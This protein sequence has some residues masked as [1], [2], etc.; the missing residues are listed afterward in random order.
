MLVLGLMLC[1]ASSASAQKYICI[2]E[3]DIERVEVVK[4]PRAVQQYG[5]QPGEGIIVITTKVG[6]GL[7]P[8]FQCPKPSG[9]GD[10]QLSTK[11]Y[12]PDLVMENQKAIGLSDSQRSKIEF[13]VKDVQ[14]KFVESQF[15]MRGE[16]EKLKTLMDQSSVDEPKVLEQIDRVLSVERDVKRAQLS[17]MMKIKNE[18]SE[19]QKSKLSKIRGDDIEYMKARGKLKP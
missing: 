12:P 3:E 5:I 9:G 11:L 13:V 19:D 17:L 1:A 10:D 18:L 15:K 2:N 6:T 8:S 7:Q 14:G 16:M 4:G